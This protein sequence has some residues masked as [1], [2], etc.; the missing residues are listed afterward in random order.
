MKTN[1]NA[2]VVFLL[3]TLLGV[4]CKKNDSATLLKAAGVKFND[5]VKV[6]LI[7]PEVGCS[8]CIAG[9]VYFLL[10]NR[11]LFSKKQQENKVVFTA[12]TSMKMLRRNLE[13]IDIDSLN[14]E[15]DTV[16]RYLLPEPEGLYP[17]IIYLNNG[18]IEEIDI[19]S[20]ENVSI[21]HKLSKR[22]KDGQ[23]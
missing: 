11:D 3:L 9:G 20:P 14:C 12:I 10:E 21:F 5:E 4:A 16:N 6:C 17:I 7:M 1:K 23:K 22:L 2:A 13:N 8:G 19:Q 15:I 18:E